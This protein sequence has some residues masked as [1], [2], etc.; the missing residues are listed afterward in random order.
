MK[1]TFDQPGA[2]TLFQ[3]IRHQTK[4]EISCAL[5]QRLRQESSCST[6]GQFKTQLRPGHHSFLLRTNPGLALELHQI[7]QPPK[8]MN[9][10]LLENNR[11]LIAIPAGSEHHLR[12]ELKIQQLIRP[13]C[14]KEAA[15]REPLHFFAVQQCLQWTSRL[16]QVVLQLG[17]R[18]IGQLQCNAMGAVN[19]HRKPSKRLMRN[20]G[21][22]T[23]Q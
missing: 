8:A 22:T 1:S 4:G 21:T 16:R 18:C 6:R 7:L 9:R 17:Q 20:D 23:G 12:L 11:E 14:I 3:A 10:A 15:I 19:L 5:H 13:G 2:T